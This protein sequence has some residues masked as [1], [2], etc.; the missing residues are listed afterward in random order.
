[1]IKFEHEVLY[2]DLSKRNGAEEM[3]LKLK[4]WGAAGFELVSVVAHGPTNS[5]VSTFFKRA[6]LVDETDEGIGA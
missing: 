2:F 3:E 1:M 4:E 6:I 5:Q